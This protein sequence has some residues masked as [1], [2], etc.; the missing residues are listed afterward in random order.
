MRGFRFVDR[1]VLGFL[2]LRRR[3]DIFRRRGGD[4]FLGDCERRLNRRGD[5]FLSRERLRDR[6]LGGVRRLDLLLRNL[7]FL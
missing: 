6:R 4:F 2:G 5:R 1:F 7:L 3:G